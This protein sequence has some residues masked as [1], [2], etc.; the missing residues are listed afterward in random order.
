M[1]R[2][3]HT[4]PRANKPWLPT[5]YPPRVQKRHDNSTIKLEIGVRAQAACGSTLTFGRQ[6]GGVA[7]ILTTPCL[8]PSSAAGDSS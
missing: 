8:T 2:S 1:R 6:M 7:T 5:G 3:V 4:K